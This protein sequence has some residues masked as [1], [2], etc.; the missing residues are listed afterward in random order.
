MTAEAPAPGGE[1]KKHARS[2]LAEHPAF[3]LFWC[4]RTAS[5]LSFQMQAVAVGWQIYELTHSTFQLGMVGLAQFL[6]MVLLTLPAGHAA[7]RYN[8]T[9][10][11]GTSTAIQGLAIVGMAFASHAHRLTPAGIF[12][13]VAFIGAAKA[14]ER[15]AASA[16]MP[17]LVPEKLVPQGI[18]LSSA[19]MQTAFVIGPAVGGILYGWGAA[20]TYAAAAGLALLAAALTFMI[21][22]E[23]SARPKE[24]PT[25]ASV[26]SGIH[27]IRRSPIILG[28]ISLDL[29]AVL[30]G[31]A[32]ALLPAYARDILHI[33]ATGL[34][35]LRAAPAVGSLLMSFI[36]AHRPL[37]GN[38]GRKMFA[39]VFSFGVAT[40]IFGLSRWV[41]LSFVALFLMGA[42]DM[43]SVVVRS[44]L[45]QLQTP[46][47]MRGRVSA[48]NSLFIG[49][50]NQLGEF[51]SGITASLFGTVP[52]TVLG[53]LGTIVV[54]GLWM[55]FFPAL[56]AFD[57]LQP[58]P[59]AS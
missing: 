13:A 14:F 56:V 15:P 19:A 20:V 31:G 17:N 28:S 47:A 5:A 39:A 58:A 21:R 36:L 18:A 51:E 10:T 35:A 25:L 9:I 49:T 59:K 7:D 41:A 42:S 53:G 26:F 55:R 44:S 32:T 40:V 37:A 8:R 57:R 12:A 11:A 48:V 46:D 6:P 24:P 22:Q 30:L 2:L 34:G 50:S 54:C 4:A 16:L 27:F 52:A 45:V 38:V 29:F 43:V 33:G 3:R 23:R 1:P